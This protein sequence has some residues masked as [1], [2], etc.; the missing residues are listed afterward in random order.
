MQDDSNVFL[1]SNIV[2][3][4]LDIDEAK[5]ASAWDLL[6]N[7]PYISVQV[8]NECSSILNRKKKLQ[9]E[10][11]EE[12]LGNLLA[13]VTVQP[14]D[15]ATVQLAWQLQAKY[16]YAYYDSLIIA[17]AL[18]SGSTTLFSEDMQH[19]QVIEDKLTIIDPF[20]TI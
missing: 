8:L 14:I 3:Y 1:D 11:I 16:R 18:E 7:K 6:F 5:R 12:V 10:T 17:A 20:K 9:P 13:F 4:A 2:L 15:V 19:G